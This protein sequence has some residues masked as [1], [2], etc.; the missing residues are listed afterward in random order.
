MNFVANFVANFV[1]NFVD[2]LRFMAPNAC[3]KKEGGFP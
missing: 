2:S 3:L 1:V